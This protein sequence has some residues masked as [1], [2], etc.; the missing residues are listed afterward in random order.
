MENSQKKKYKR[1]PLC[2]KK[3][4]YELKDSGLSQAEVAKQFNVRPSTVQYLWADKRFGK[5]KFAKNSYTHGE[6]N[7]PRKEKTKEG[8]FNV[9]SRWNWLI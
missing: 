4:M 3:A 2:D 8:F 6:R 7:R 5:P 1:I 9:T